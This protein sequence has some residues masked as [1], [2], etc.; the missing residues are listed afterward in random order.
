[1]AVGGQQTIS[2]EHRV[3]ESSE[4]SLTQVRFSQSLRLF[5][6]FC[7]F[8]FFPLRVSSDTEQSKKK[9]LFIQIE[10]FSVPVK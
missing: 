2:A 4:L 5:L 6:F 1:M 10:I 3:T 7:V 9:N 8:F